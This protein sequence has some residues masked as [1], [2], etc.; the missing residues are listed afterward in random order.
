MNMNAIRFRSMPALLS[1]SLLGLVG[2]GAEATSDAE[3]LGAASQA[4]GEASCA[5]AGIEDVDVSGVKPAGPSSSTYSNP[6]CFKSFVIDLTDLQAANA[7]VTVSWA[8]SLPSTKQACEDLMLAVDTYTHNPNGSWSIDVASSVPPTQNG[9]WNATTN[10]CTSGPSFSL[11]DLSVGGTY[12]FSVTARKQ[13]SSTA[14][15]Q[16]FV[17][18]PLNI[19]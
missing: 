12:R 1:A 18:V 5:S 4:F 17:L 16:K 2:C 10:T 13:N 7:I 8:D 19:T 6:D 15:T 3:K 9:V 14:P 11:P